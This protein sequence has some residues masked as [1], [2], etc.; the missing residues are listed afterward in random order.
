MKQAALVF[1]GA[2]LGGL[3]GYYVFFLADSARLLRVGSSRR[4]V[5][6]GG[7]HCEM[8]FAL[9]FGHLRSDGSDSGPVHSLA[10]RPL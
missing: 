5:G 10:V 4:P 2:V 1:G 3:V 6:L 7:R 9:A 8:P